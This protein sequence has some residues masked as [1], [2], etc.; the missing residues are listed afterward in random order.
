M[1]NTTTGVDALRSL[2]SDLAAYNRQ[3]DVPSGLMSL[4]ALEPA[5][6]EAASADELRLNKALLQLK[7]RDLLAQTGLALE[8]VTTGHKVFGMGQEFEATEMRLNV[9]NG[10]SLIAFLAGLNQ[11]EGEE[12][13]LYTETLNQ[14]TEI[15][16]QQLQRYDLR[17]PGDEALELFGVLEQYID[18][19]QRLIGRSTANEQL[20]T[21]LTIARQGY[22]V[23]YLETWRLRQSGFGHA[24][25]F[26]PSIWHCDNSCESYAGDGYW[27]GAVQQVLAMGDNPKARTY[28]K[29]LAA[30]LTLHAQYARQDILTHRGEEWLTDKATGFLDTLAWVEYELSG[31]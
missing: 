12:W 31:V 13:E 26:G 28:Q 3:H 21:C 1:G 29:M 18:Q 24:S 30:H 15:L 23:E 20:Q 7:H 5:S 11:P 22:L 6:S 4:L 27:G 10:R 2:M 16:S 25:G 17:Q 14:I 19:A 8:P 9:T